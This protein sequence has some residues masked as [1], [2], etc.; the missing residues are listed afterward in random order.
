[1]THR[2]P[3][4][5]CLLILCTPLAITTIATHAT[6]NIIVQD[7]TLA[8]DA[9]HP[10]PLLRTEWWYFDAI[11]TQNYSLQASVR[12]TSIRHLGIVTTR[13]DL[14]QDGA[15]L[16]SA[17]D[18]QP[19]SR[20]TASQETPNV[21]LNGHQLI[22]GTHNTTTDTYDY[23]LTIGSTELNATLQFTGRTK[24]WKILR[25]LGD[26]WAVMCPRADVTGTIHFNNLTLTVQGIGYHDHN[27]GLGAAK[28]LRYGWY[29]G[30]VNSD[31]YTLVWS[32]I[33]T[34]RL[35]HT[36]VAVENT[37]DA[38]YEYIPPE[39]VWFAPEK[40]A[41][42]HGHFIPH[43]FFLSVQTPAQMAVIHANAI[44]VDYQDYL[45]LINYWRYHFHNT[46]SFTFGVTT[47]IVDETAIGEFIRFR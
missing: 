1:M 8:D 7:V 30:K 29:W 47:E 10:T 43:R 45:G 4:L 23:T 13:L 44:A 21:T 28:A 9:Y 6:P 3:S 31:H 14:Y 19:L 36:I 20:L 17:H 46:G 22:L 33:Q 24:G 35:T 2:I 15:P 27:W 42:D 5:L 16:A 26:G 40:Y 25:P 11:L 37:L 32:A 38:G 12:T 39:N 18:R 34:T 41:L